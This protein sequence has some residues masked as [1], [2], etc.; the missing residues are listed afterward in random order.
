MMRYFIPLVLLVAVLLLVLWLKFGRAPRRWRAWRRA[1]RLLDEGRWQDSLGEVMTL[2]AE[3]GLSPE[4][5]QRLARIAGECHQLAGNQ[6]LKAGQYEESLQHFLQTA[7]FLQLDPQQQ[8]DQ[9]IEA[10]LAQVRRLFAASTEPKGTDAVLAL[11]VRLF[12]IQSPCAEA[13]FWHGLCLLR[14]GQVEPALNILKDTHEQAGKR[15]L[16][17]ALYAGM[18][19]HRLSRPQ[20]ALRYLA[21]ANRVDPGCAFVTWQMGLSLVAAGGDSGMAI[22]ALQRALGPRGFGLWSDK[23]ERAWVEAFPEGKSYIRRLAA[24]HR[25]VCPVLGSELTPVLRLGQ[26]ALAQAHYR[27]GQYQEA[28]D[29]YDGLLRDSP[30]TIP[31][32][33]GYGLALARLERYDQAYKHLRA[34]LEQENPK[35]PLTAGYLALCGAMGKPT[36]DE[37]RPRNVSWAIRLLARYPLF[38]NPEWAGLMSRVHAEARSLD[39]ETGPDEQRQLCDVLASVHAIDTAAADAYLQLARTCPDVLQPQHAWLYVAAAVLHGHSRDNDLDLFART[40]KDAEQARAYFQERGWS[41]DTAEYTYLERSALQAPGQFP[42]P[43]GPDY[44]PRGESFLL[45]RSQQQEAASQLDS[46]RRCV[47]VLV[48]LA[49]TSQRGHDRLACLHYRQGD[50]DR[51]VALLARWQTLDPGNHWPAVRQAIIEQERGNARRR[52]EAIERALQLTQGSAR[53]A[54]AFLGARLSLRSL[55]D[56]LRAAVTSPPPAAEELSRT[57]ALLEACLR[58]EPQHVEALWCLAAVRSLRDDRAA[59]AA[60]AAQMNR[61]SVT[62]AR[63]HYMGAVCHLAAESPNMVLELSERAAQDEQLRADSYFLM[64][65]AHLHRNDPASAAAALEK[66]AGVTQSPSAPLA[67]ALLGKLRFLA[68]QPEQAAQWWQQIEPAQRCAWQLDEPLRQAVLLSG[69]AALRDQRF[70]QAADRFQQAGKLGLRYRALGSLMSFALLRAGQRL[71][72]C[73][74]ADSERQTRKAETT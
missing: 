64:A 52:D 27:Q 59:L 65:W 49:P 21:E 14:Q 22:R 18:L 29:L 63:F 3:P 16:D 2:Q 8:R 11:L 42:V 26:L 36:R 73:Q 44:P 20:E 4:W 50:T 45:E 41:F 39:M 6:A 15:F 60:Q 69:L 19:L 43:L 61:P 55:R 51:A 48:R 74:A 57:Q 25:Y 28:A 1:Q 35:D 7:A 71:L 37:D 13:S 34:A 47:E 24:N 5:Q 54:I 33:R 30:P 9:V 46:A 62:D 70:E 31:L 67:C 12:Q 53:A 66:V 68:S 10:M 40:F 72:Y 56:W 38:E 17:P 58:E 23:P 32:L